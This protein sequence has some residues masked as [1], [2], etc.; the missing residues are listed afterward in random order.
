MSGTF[1]GYFTV[2]LAL[3]LGWLGVRASPAEELGPEVNVAVRV[4]NY[5]GVP[6]GT[7]AQAEEGA[8]GIFRQAGIGFFWVD[9]PL[10][11][12]EIGRF[13]ACTTIR[14]PLAPTLKI[15]PEAMATG[16]HAPPGQFG[17]TI[18]PHGSFVFFHRVEELAKVTGIA[19]RVIL[20]HIMAHELGHLMLGEGN[21]SA[22]GIMS[23]DL[24][25]KEF[26]A[27][28][29]GTPL[30]FSPQQAQRMRARLH[31]EVLAKK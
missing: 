14:D 10:T 19:L 27:A 5:A 20:S 25:L 13:P 22:S 4:Y 29:M 9:C 23:V 2:G 12:E 6:V 1:R 21:H 8:A 11:K 15:L 28:E 7:L 26:R 17:I 24:H 31:G 3:T 16:L 18:Q 30:L